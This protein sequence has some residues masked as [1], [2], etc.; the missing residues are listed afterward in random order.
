MGNVKKHIT[1]M[2]ANKD[3]TCSMVD[4]TCSGGRTALGSISLDGY[5]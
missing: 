3:T 5:Q 4:F 2:M 1:Q